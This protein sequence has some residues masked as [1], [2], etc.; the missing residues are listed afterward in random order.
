M[1][2]L[3]DMLWRNPS[4]FPSRG[5]QYTI[6]QTMLQRQGWGGLP[7]WGVFQFPVPRDVYYQQL[8]TASASY[9][10]GLHGVK[11]GCWH[12]DIEWPPW[13]LGTR[14]DYW[15]EFDH[16]LF[17]LLGCLAASVL[18]GHTFIAAGGGFITDK[19]FNQSPKLFP[20]QPKSPLLSATG[21]K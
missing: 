5:W 3:E 12:P 2:Y 14:M 18:S 6:S 13:L 21:L 16:Y 15:L 1:K 4:N 9:G 19:R 11:G 8:S 17:K 7:K 20:V 10:W